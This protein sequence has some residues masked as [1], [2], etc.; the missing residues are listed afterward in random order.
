MAVEKDNVMSID[1]DPIVFA[2]LQSDRSGA[3]MR[4]A[5]WS[6]LTALVP[7]ALSALVFLITSR[8]LN[9]SD[10]G[11]VAL[12]FSIV[13]FVSAV[14][15]L[16]FDQAIIQQKD[17]RRSHLDSVFWL[18]LVW[19]AML[20][21][22]LALSASCIANWVSQPI[23]R[24]MLMIMGVKI[25]FDLLAV[26]PN[27][28]IGRTMAFHLAA[29]RTVVATV[30]SAVICLS[31]LLLGYRIWAIV[32]AQISSSAASCIAAYWGAK[33]IPGTNI[34]FTSLRDLRKYGIFAS[35]N[36]FFQVMSLDQLL[37]G[38]LIGPA[39]LG[40]YNFARRIFQIMN[41][42]VTGGLTSVSHALFSSLQSEQGKVRDAFLLSTF[43]CSLIAFPVFMGLAAIS[44]DFIP[45]AFGEQWAPA[46]W[47][48]RFFCV[49]GLMSGIG[50]IQASL[51]NSQGKSDW[52]FYY[53][54]F[55]NVTTVI[56][57]YL[58][59]DQGISVIVF[60]IMMQV[61]ILWPVT[62]FM[63]SRLIDLRVSEYIK[64]FAR[65]FAAYAG[66]LII[67]SLVGHE[68][69]SYT[70]IARMIIQVVTGGITYISIIYILC[71]EEIFRVF[72][73][74]RSARNRRHSKV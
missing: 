36:K 53:Q 25:F 12:S 22:F 69:D 28:L 54:L 15:P 38:T 49:I 65:P 48:V 73:L 11:I 24:P 21:V 50:V 27:G 13:S 34:K 52:W 40:I 66:L 74:F 7:S 45:F 20:Y 16:A 31:L 68:L 10:F 39:P 1:T 55:R 63:V 58:L 2:H 8:F 56:S 41:D 67:T 46:V 60:S 4:G 5:M 72:K 3:A 29:T 71:K 43:G 61:L 35:G 62:L 6:A 30:A 26:I 32:I 57:V 23:I 64:Q 14:G 18:A 44:S 70:P 42:V 33:W 47:P 59:R 51:I 17:I 37:I 9:P 19:A